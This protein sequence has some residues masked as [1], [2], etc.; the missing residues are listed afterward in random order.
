MDSHFI[1]SANGPWYELFYNLAFFIAIVIFLY[2]GYQRKFPLLK[3]IFLIA[4]TQLL[5]IIGTKL[6][7]FS[8]HDFYIMFSRFELPE[9]H[10]KSLSGGLLFVG[11]GLLAGTYLLRFKQNITDAFALTLPLGIAIQRIGCFIT[12]CCYGKISYLPWAVKYPVQTLPHYHQFNDNLISHNDFLSLPV[13]PVQLY[14]MAGLLAVVF[15]IFKFRK[16]FKKAGSLFVLSLI[17]IFTVRFS[18][19]FIRDV[20]A[21]TTGGEMIWIFNS[22]QLFLLPGTLILIFILYKREKTGPVTV[23]K[24]YASDFGLAQAFFLLLLLSVCLR[25]LK[26]W[27][28]FPEIAAMFVTLSVAYAI[29]GFR[30]FQRLYFS[31]YRW[32]YLAGFVLP[33]FLMAQTFP[34]NEHDSLYVKKYKTIKLGFAT[35]DFENSHSIGIGEG[36]DRVSNT[37]YFRQKYTLGGA[38]FEFTEEYP[39]KKQQF[40]YGAKTMFGNHTETRLSDNYEKSI[41]LF[42]ITPYATFETN[43]VGIGGGL[44]IGN[45]SIITENF[46]EDGY[47][48]PETGSTFVKI[49]PQFHFR[50]GPQRWF[51]AD[52]RMADHFP[53]ALPGFRHQLG[54]GTGLG[55]RNGTNIRL[56]SNLGD[57]FYFSGYVPIEKK[58]VIEPMIL[59]G[60]SP[61]YTTAKN[62]FQYSLGV[63]YRFDFTEGKRVKKQKVN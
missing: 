15:I 23:S 21:H 17:L 35:G 41:T 24:H 39:E 16:S 32:L 59:W 44:H 34:S 10:N 22:T 26:N 19:E 61:Q 52:Y 30:I 37:E 31:S 33:F 51:F 8:A 18:A 48:I 55:T 58:F 29:L 60:Q 11:I 49:Y 42:W 36:C 63:G 12:G 25:L 2:E 38:A 27:L 43:W 45:L 9:T 7:T 50:L 3:W 62:Y 13:H 20:N 53:S 4:M 6:A 40:R 1:V 54:V 14:E 28:V 46:D 47:G 57:I 5:F 56:G